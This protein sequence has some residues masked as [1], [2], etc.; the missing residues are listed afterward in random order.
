MA[1]KG[2][3]STS[4]KPA[5]SGAARTGVGR[6]VAGETDSRSR[7]CLTMLSDV[8]AHIP[9][10]I[11]HSLSDVCVTVSCVAVTCPKLYV[12]MKLSHALF[13]GCLRIYRIYLGPRGRQFPKSQS[14]A[15]R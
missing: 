13:A 7:T 14:C 11:I 4:V 3:S 1:R 5:L 2:T 15:I 8:F 6:A 10:R 9:Y 12:L